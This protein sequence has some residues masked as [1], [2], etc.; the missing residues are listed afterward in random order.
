MVCGG[1]QRLKGYDT[2]IGMLAARGSW[3]RFTATGHLRHINLMPVRMI[4]LTPK[5]PCGY[6]VLGELTKWIWRVGEGCLNETLQAANSKKGSYMPY[7]LS[8]NSGPS[9]R[10]RRLHHPP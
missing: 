4:G 3:R 7:C 1:S 5:H 8:S 9:L 2:H 6:N 10:E